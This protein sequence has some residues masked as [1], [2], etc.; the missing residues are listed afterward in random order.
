LKLILSQ[1]LHIKAV[2]KIAPTPTGGT[3]NNQR[4]S[5]RQ[6]RWVR[7]HKEAQRLRED[8]R[9]ARVTGAG[10]CFT[11][12]QWEAM[13]R[14][15]D[16]RCLCCGRKEPETKLTP[17][18]VIPLALGGGLGIDNIQPLCRSCNSKKRRNTTDYRPKEERV[19]G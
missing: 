15:Y 4:K 11:N 19:N 7:R 18:H 16:Y 8:I 2:S 3:T 17:D 1:S 13:K 10:G 12:E 6:K 9:R 5:E 14:H